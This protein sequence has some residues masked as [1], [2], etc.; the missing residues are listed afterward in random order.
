MLE[1]KQK[2]QQQQ[3][4][5][6][7]FFW[8]LDRLIFWY[9]YLFLNSISHQKL[10]FHLLS[11]NPSSTKHTS[12]QL[13]VIQEKQKRCHKSW[14]EPF[15]QYYFGLFFFSFCISPSSGFSRSHRFGASS[16]RPAHTLTPTW[17]THHHLRPSSWQHTRSS[18]CL[19]RGFIIDLLCVS[20]H[21]C[22]STWPVCTLSLRPLLAGS[23][24]FL[25]FTPLPLFPSQP[26][27]AFMEMAVSIK[28]FIKA[29]PS[30][31]CLPMENFTAAFRCFPVMLS[32]STAE[33]SYF[34]LTWVHFESWEDCNQ[35]DKEP[36]SV[37][38]NT[39]ITLS[40]GVFF[41]PS[42]FHKNLWKHTLQELKDGLEVLFSL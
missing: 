40:A 1:L 8:I 14:T 35:N 3:N 17:S 12:V 26:L 19:L 15:V 9:I 33:V 27:Q 37:N 38:E 23:S 7:R 32:I 22:D 20:D 28:A 10:I 4:K 41:F 11:K 5:S 13:T 16:T 6:W 29:P 25:V 2:Q 39:L 34:L 18:L 31:F 42:Q 21:L 24:P 36:V 30:S